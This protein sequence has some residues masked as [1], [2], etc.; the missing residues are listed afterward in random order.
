MLVPAVAIL[1]AWGAYGCAVALGPGYTVEK[2]QIEVTYT[3]EAPD[4]IAVRAS[5]QLENTGTKPLEAL[6]LELPAA[7]TFPAQDTRI[8][9]RGRALP[10]ESAA[11]TN[12][13]THMPLGVRWGL[14]DGG[15][16][17]VTYNLKIGSEKAGADSAQGR[18]FFLPSSGWYPLLLPAEGLF[19]T[20]GTPP[21][22]WELA[23]SVP[24]GY[25]VHASGDERGRVRSSGKN[26]TRTD[27]V[28]EQ[29][30][31]I[32]FEPFVV[33]GPY[34]EQEVHSSA[35]TILLWSAQPI[36]PK[37]AD[38]IGERIG[39][40]IDFFRSEFG[41]QE[42]EKRQTWIIGCPSG[43]PIATVHPGIS[44]TDCLAEPRSAIVSPDFFGSAAPQKAMEAV[45]LQLAATWLQFPAQRGRYSPMFP[46]AAIENYAEFALN[47]SENPASRD[48]AVRELLQRVAANPIAEKPLDKVDRKDSAGVL[49]R[50]QMQSELFFIALE[51]R[52][53]AQNLHRGIARASRLLRGQSWSL[54]DLRSAV[55]AECGGP[56]L[57][58]FF[59]EWMHGQGV[60]EDFR[61]RY[62]GAA[63]AKSNE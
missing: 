12:G 30:P 57:E 3:A 37:R 33:A 7:E 14:G 62:L 50:A 26:A 60:P 28:F 8:E 32:S 31:G 55:E 38:E 63:A 42:P 40:H 23:V 44:Q 61:A 9:W 19:S 59:R 56:V 34:V 1:A 10:E 11:N 52:C 35:G 18:A 17:I 29:K 51:D 46:L 20:G 45:D 43:E 49:E 53:G 36:S 5:Y 2:Q 27:L 24:E 48:A 13:I 47:T 16:L 41:S 6:D 15:E 25:R 22:K 39:S 58:S 54:P 21:I 4:R